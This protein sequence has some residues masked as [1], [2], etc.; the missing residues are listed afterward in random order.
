MQSQP[1]ALPPGVDAETRDNRVAG[2]LLAD[3]PAA[4]RK[5]MEWAIP[6]A[7]SAVEAIVTKGM[8]AAMNEFN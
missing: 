2:Y 8:T 3:F 1:A 4:E 6:V 5:E 7:A